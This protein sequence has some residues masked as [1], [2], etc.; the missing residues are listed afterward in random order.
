MRCHLA[1]LCLLPAIAFGGIRPHQELRDVFYGEILYYAYQEDFFEAISHLD[2]ELGQYYALDEP[3]L[4]TFNFHRDQAEFSVGDIELSYRMHQRAGRALSRVLDEN[5]EPGERN[6]A[7]FRLARLYYRK[8]EYV[9]ALH[10]IELIKGEVPEKIASDETF[11]RAQIYAATGKF[12]DAIKLLEGM[13]G[14]AEY[15]GYTEYNLAMA[16]LQ[17]G[18]QEKGLEMLDELGTLGTDDKAVLA[19]KDKGNLKL[20]FYYLEEGQPQKASGYFERV[21]LDGPFSNRALLGAGWVEVA[22]KRFDRALVPWTLLHGRLQ[23]NESVQ[24]AMMSVPY[25]YSKLDVHGKAAIMYGRALD[26]FGSEIDSLDAS[27]KSIREGK[28]LLALIDKQA[29]K[30]KN[31]VVNLRDLPDSPETR[32]IMELLAGHDFQESLKNYKDLAELRQYLTEWLYNLDVFEEIIAI[33]RAYY[34]PLLPEI[35]KEFKKLDSRIKLRIEQRGRLN[36][37]IQSMLIARRPE[38]L[39]T[40]NERS[41]IDT[42]A[43]MKVDLEANP[44]LMTEAVRYRMERLEGVLQWRIKLDYDA[45]LTTAYEHLQE[46]D[47]EIDGMNKRYRS[48]VRTRQAATQSYE[49]YAIPIQQLRTRLKSAQLKLRGVMARQGR[50]LEQ[51][52]INELDRRRK[53][54]EDYQ[55]KA[56]F[57]LAESYDRATKAQEKEEI[58]ALEARARE[59]QLKEMQENPVPVAPAPATKPEVTPAPEPA[60]SEPAASEPEAAP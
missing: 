23:T 1:W 42:L 8:Q 7:A 24:E 31:W 34:E 10:A 49:G 41:V 18:E 43:K 9:S 35:E 12:A 27:I 47:D 21:R 50:V 36:D 17:S 19:L 25:A 51:L 33:R 53:R 3:E 55:V 2:N 40:A 39:A 28:F 11:L 48:F 5:V 52:A 16:Y 30:D 44:A 56:R 4:D 46:L 22:E 60:T 32:Y 26:V 38:Y 58:E 45:R 37:R 20:A 6:D 57:A 13:R 59:S 15:R 54:L 14:K 29:D